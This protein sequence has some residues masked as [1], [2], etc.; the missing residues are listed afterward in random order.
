MFFFVFFHLFVFFPIIIRRIVSTAR[1]RSSACVKFACIVCNIIFISSYFRPLT[2]NLPQGRRDREW[3]G[4]KRDLNKLGRKERRP[5]GRAE[6][7]WGWTDSEL[8]KKS[9]QDRTDETVPMAA[10][11]MLIGHWW[12]EAGNCWV[13]RARS[14][15]SP[16]R[17]IIITTYLLRD[18]TDVPAGATARIASLIF[19]FYLTDSSRPSHSQAFIFCQPSKL[20]TAWGCVLGCRRS[21]WHWWND[22]PVNCRQIRVGS[23]VTTSFLFL[24]LCSISNVK[25]LS[26]QTLAAYGISK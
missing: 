15:K 10:L 24:L 7:S 16:L 3:A 18:P 14:V 23:K 9:P 5:V 12:E 2:L 4:Y 26:M 20:T 11:S 17:F 1:R 22:V 6:H 21:E 19:S 8:K 25:I 13:A